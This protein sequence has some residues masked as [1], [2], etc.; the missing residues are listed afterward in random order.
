MAGSKFGCNVTTLSTSL[1]VVFVVA[2]DESLR[3][4]TV[5]R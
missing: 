4:V 5:T 2:D 3:A 1:L